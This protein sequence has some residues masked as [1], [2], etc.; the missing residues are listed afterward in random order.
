MEPS[1]VPYGW[2]PSA[3]SFLHGMTL[4]PLATLE[5]KKAQKKLLYALRC[6]LPCPTCRRSYRVISRDLDDVKS[7]EI[8]DYVLKLHDKV[9]CKLYQLSHF[10][11][12][13][14]SSYVEDMFYFLFVV[15]CNY[16]LNYTED[17]NQKKWYQI[18]FEQLPLA[19]N[20]RKWGK[21]MEK[22]ASRNPVSTALKS[23]EKLVS[24]V[25][26]MY[27]LVLPSQSEKYS[28]DSI[29]KT[30]ET[31]RKIKDN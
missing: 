11:E 15:A 6:V 1:T 9:N 5:N 4:D 31:I 14:Y 21:T 8:A 25:Y 24:Y 23:R 26:E 12:M 10:R 22:Y 30:I 16:P 13:G 17:T 28:L 3:W 7:D 19:I 18:F 29:C 27:Q 20:E 2:G